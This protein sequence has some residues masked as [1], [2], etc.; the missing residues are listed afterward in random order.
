MKRTLRQ[1]RMRQA[2]ALPRPEP[3]CPNCG[4]PGRHFVPPS[5]GGRDP[6]FYHCIRVPRMTAIESGDETIFIPADEFP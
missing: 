3:V 6:G 5:G 4:Q 1:I 2:F